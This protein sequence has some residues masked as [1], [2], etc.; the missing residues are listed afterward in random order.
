MRHPF[1]VSVSHSHTAQT[2][3]LTVSKLL[4]QEKTII[5]VSQAYTLDTVGTPQRVLKMFVA[6]ST[7]IPY[8][9]C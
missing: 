7:Y 2:T 8:L 1:S 5:Y 6:G 9:S 4:L 3:L